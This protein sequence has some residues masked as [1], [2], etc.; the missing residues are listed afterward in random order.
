M[1]SSTG[2]DST[3]GAVA[4]SWYAIWSHS[5]CE[6]VVHDQLRRK[7][8]HAFLPTIDVWS[9]RRGV[10]RLISV[11]MFPSYLF[12]RGAMDKTLYLEVSKVRGVARVLGERWDRLT[13]IP[14][15]EIRAIE[16]VA[17]SRERVLPYPY[18]THG[19][20]VRITSGPLI[21]LEGVLVESRPQQG[22]LVLS[23][24]QLHRSVAV[25]VD[26]AAVEPA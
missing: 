1:Q 5:H 2:D 22:L 8:H 4:G 12:V 21:G 16:I 14:D 9:R 25:V 3:K 18:L 23:I 7:G 13:A 26:G 17:A 15:E 24:H 19:Q 11:P 6:Q 10:R 20:R